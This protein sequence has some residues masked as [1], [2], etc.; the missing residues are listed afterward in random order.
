MRLG[1][2]ATTVM[3]GENSMTSEK[4]FRSS[5]SM[6]ATHDPEVLKRFLKR[7]YSAVENL[8]WKSKPSVANTMI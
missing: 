6:A 5:R 2:T 3:F 1:E 4:H 7:A 8:E